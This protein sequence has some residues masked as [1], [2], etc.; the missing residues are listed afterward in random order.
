MSKVA[1]DFTCGDLP[2]V[3]VKIDQIWADS[4]QK[5]DFITNVQ[6]TEAVHANQTARLEVLEGSQKDR[7]LKIMWLAMCQSMLADCGDMCTPGGPEL[8]SDCKE[9]A[10][11]LCQ[12][13]GF[14][15]R[16]TAFRNNIWTP[17]E[18]IARA[19]MQ[20]DKELSIWTD[21][22]V[23]LALDSYAGVN[24]FDT[25]LGTVC[26]HDTWIPAAF[27]TPDLLGYFLEAAVMNDQNN[28]YGISGHNLYSQNWTAMMN[29]GNA[30]GSG[31]KNMME[32]MKMY[33]DLRNLDRVLGAKKTFVVEPSAMA[34]GTKNYYSTTHREISNG[35]DI[36]Q[37]AVQS[38]ILPWIIDDITYKTRCE[39]SE[40]FHDFTRWRRLGVYQNPLPCNVELTGVMSFVCGD[41]PC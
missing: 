37:W 25:G 9:Y 14:T 38:K 21:E 35:A 18:V 34:I 2:I 33:F 11:N 6:A 32:A 5:I 28:S 36:T 22:Q 4:A 17:E 31:A 19:F 29:A 39:G 16:E 24:Q 41:A 40:I 7:Q 10:L 3:E 26:G 8:E 13:A 15:V 27:W 20:A 12:S 23:I 1:G 30:S